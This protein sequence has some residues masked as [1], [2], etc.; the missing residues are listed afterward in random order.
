MSRNWVIIDHKQRSSSPSLRPVLCP[1]LEIFV[2]MFHGA[3]ML[4]DLLIPPIWWPEISV[5]IW[6]SPV[7]WL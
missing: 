6:S 4:E 3:A 7:L 5:N 1:K 2:D